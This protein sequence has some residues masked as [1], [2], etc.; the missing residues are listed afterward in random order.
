MIVYICKEAIFSPGASESLDYFSTFSE[1]DLRICTDICP[2]EGDFLFCLDEKKS[3]FTG[4][5]ITFDK[6]N[7][8]QS[9]KTLREEVRSQLKYVNSISISWSYQHGV[10]LN[11]NG[12]I[13]VEKVIVNLS[14]K[15]VVIEKLRVGENCVLFDTPIPEN[16]GWCVKIERCLWIDGRSREGF[17][18]EC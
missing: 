1:I 2:T 15:D 6:R 11:N 7:P 13:E 18:L 3:K 8:N 14:D 12:T 4:Q 10:V 5:I 16:T 9:W 17:D